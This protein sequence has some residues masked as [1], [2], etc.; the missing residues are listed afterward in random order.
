MKVEYCFGRSNLYYQSLLY[1]LPKY[2][3]PLVFSFG[4]F[5]TE[6]VP[7][8]KGEDFTF[9]VDAARCIVCIMIRFNSFTGVLG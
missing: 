2:N 3:F 8:M 5:H 7:C 4:L 9:S 1:A 6:V